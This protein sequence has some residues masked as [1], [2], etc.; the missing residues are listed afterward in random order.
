MTWVIYAT[1]AI[2][3]MG[4]S[5]IFRKV[6][7]G[8]KDPFFVN[9][10]FQTSAW[11]T[12]VLLFVLFSRRTET[13]FNYIL[14][15]IIGGITICIFTIFSFK[16]LSIGPGVSVV[17]PS[18]RIGGVT[19]VAILGVLILKEKLSMQSFAGMILSAIGIYLL[20]TNK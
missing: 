13:N 12:A 3:L 15:A 14:S 17:M 10:I 6:A 16:S 9:L 20:F 18:L 1:I 8:L 19:L 7:S 2:G 11:I 4:I 5:D